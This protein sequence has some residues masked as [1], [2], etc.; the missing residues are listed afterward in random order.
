[1]YSIKRVNNSV[2][3]AKRKKLNNELIK[4]AF[5][6]IKDSGSY[7]KRNKLNYITINHKRKLFK[8]IEAFYHEYTHF[9]FQFLVNNNLIIYA[10]SNKVNIEK[11]EDDICYKLDNIARKTFLKELKNFIFV[12]N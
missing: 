2:V 12:I 11:L 4:I 1:M 8:F 9:L 6:H 7:F 5:R 10:G 3:I